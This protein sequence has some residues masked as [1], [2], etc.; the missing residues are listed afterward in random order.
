MFISRS[1]FFFSSISMLFATFFFL[2][3][4]CAAAKLLLLYL[5]RIWCVKSYLFW[6]YLSVALALNISFQFFFSVMLRVRVPSSFVFYPPLIFVCSTRVWSENLFIYFVFLILHRVSKRQTTKHWKSNVISREMTKEKSA[7]IESDMLFSMFICSCRMSRT[8]QNLRERENLLSIATLYQNQIE[9]FRPKKAC[10]VHTYIAYYGKI[11]RNRNDI[12]KQKKGMNEHWRRH[13]H[14]FLLCQSFFPSSA[15]NMNERSSNFS[16]V[17]GGY[18]L[19]PNSSTYV[20][21]QLSVSVCNPIVLHR[22]NKN[23]FTYFSF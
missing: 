6:N 22:Q 20:F 7:S 4:V 17:S 3:F 1:I 11:V 23:Q 18:T 2:L 15:H 10:T 8:A 5:H 21:F 19:K 9:N 16:N 12:E 14:P 13:S